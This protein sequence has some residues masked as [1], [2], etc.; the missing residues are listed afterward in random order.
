ME[1]LNWKVACP[2]ISGVELGLAMSLSS[3]S[4]IE[5]GVNIDNYNSEYVLTL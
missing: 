5:A 3:T 1:T 2:K 4:Y